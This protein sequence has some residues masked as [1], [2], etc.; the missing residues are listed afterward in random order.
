MSSTACPLPLTDH[1]SPGT[2]PDSDQL[3]PSH[4]S[5]SARPAKP[6][7]TVAAAASAIAYC[8]TDA[9]RSSVDRLGWDAGHT[10]R[11]STNLRQPECGSKLFDDR[12]ELDALPQGSA[13]HMNRTP[14]RP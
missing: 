7:V 3:I 13:R 8:F 11:V 1:E 2:R 10:T 6:A 4:T 5:A 12:H 9:I 14:R